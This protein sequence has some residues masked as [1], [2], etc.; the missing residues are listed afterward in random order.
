DET[1]ASRVVADD[2]DMD[3][4]Q[5]E[6]DTLAISLIAKRQPMA[7]DLR[8]VVA[9][10]RIA[11]DLERIGD[12]AKNIAKRVGAIGSVERNLAR[13]VETMTSLVLDQLSG[14]IEGHAAHDAEALV[15]L[16]L[17]DKLIDVEYTA[18]FRE[19]LT[20]MMEDPRN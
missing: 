15:A 6:L 20:Y 7:Q 8:T 4:A 18:I 2:R 10:I 16:R 11:G 12:L 3:A 9:A 14:V 5:R 17:D 19:L 13:S 1:L